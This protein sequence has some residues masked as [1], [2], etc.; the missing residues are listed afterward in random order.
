MSDILE[1]NAMV[2]ELR[3]RK[4]KICYTNVN[5]IELVRIVYFSDTNH[6]GLKEVYCQAR[7]LTEF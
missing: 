1:A 2:H 7:V 6:A 5:E 3:K 4:Y